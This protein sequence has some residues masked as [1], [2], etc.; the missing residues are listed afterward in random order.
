M[1]TMICKCASKCA[2]VCLFEM[3]DLSVGLHS[4]HSAFRMPALDDSGV[5][6]LICYPRTVNRFTG[7]IQTNKIRPVYG[8][9]N[10]KIIELYTVHSIK[11][12][13]S[14]SFPSLR[15]K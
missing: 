9:T 7:E 1:Q 2:T 10:F 4:S 5:H 6:E 15:I 12:S 13:T 8:A 11:L 14:T 3:K